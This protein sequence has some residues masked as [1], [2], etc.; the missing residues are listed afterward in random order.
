MA[1]PVPG[2]GQIDF[3]HAAPSSRAGS[4]ATGLR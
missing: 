2:G 3:E 1:T 4:G